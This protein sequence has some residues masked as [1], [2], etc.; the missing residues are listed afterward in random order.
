M[1]K[2]VA[3]CLE[4]KIY[5]Y[6]LKTYNKDCGF[7]YREDKICDSTVWGVKHNP[8]NRDIFCSYGGDGYVRL[9]KY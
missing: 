9:M 7:Q 3:S 1:N 8:F 4:G 2:L 5:T 6:D